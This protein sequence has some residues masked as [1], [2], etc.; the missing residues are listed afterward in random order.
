MFEFA[1]E[2]KIDGVL[3]AATDYGVLTASY[4]A[5]HLGIPGLN[6]ESAKLIKNKYLVRKRLY[7]NHVDDTE[8]TLK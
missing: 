3:T 4:I 8:Q 1:R 7:E 6:Y 5:E 2:E